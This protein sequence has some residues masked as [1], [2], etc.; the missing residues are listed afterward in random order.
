MNDYDNR[1]T[2]EYI[3]VA[4]LV[5]LKECALC[6]Q[7]SSSLG[8][9]VTAKMINVALLNTGFGLALPEI[10]QWRSRVSSS[11]VVCL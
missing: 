10:R 3:F 6:M 9:N 7:E 4:P 11:A 1:S 2:V 8:C 5:R